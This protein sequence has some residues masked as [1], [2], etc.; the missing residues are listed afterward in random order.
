[1]VSIIREALNFCSAVLPV[2][3]IPSPM[4][5]ATGRRRG[6]R[7]GRGCRGGGGIGAGDPGRERRRRRGREDVELFIGRGHRS[8]SLHARSSNFWRQISNPTLLHATLLKHSLKHN[9]SS[10]SSSSSRQDRL[11]RSQ[12]MTFQCRG[13]RERTRATSAVRWWNGRT[14]ERYQRRSIISPTICGRHR[15]KC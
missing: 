4:E 15:Q 12:Q 13:N 8:T 2:Q 9:H 7:G 6:R 5:L 11:T 3:M 14:R 1:M 10:S